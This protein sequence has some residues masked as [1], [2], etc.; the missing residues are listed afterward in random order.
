MRYYIVEAG[1]IDEGVHNLEDL[2]LAGAPGFIDE[3]ENLP[4]EA[5]ETAGG[6]GFVDLFRE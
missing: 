4:P 3:I 5:R 1:C 2:L 6:L